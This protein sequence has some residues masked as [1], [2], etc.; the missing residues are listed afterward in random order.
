VPSCVTYYNGDQNIMTRQK[1][2]RFTAGRVREKTT[3]LSFSDGHTY[4]SGVDGY[5]RS[6]VV[7]NTPVWC[8]I[9]V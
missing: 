4:K 8:I 3:N 5:I 7:M 9:R 2:G 1:N 6:P